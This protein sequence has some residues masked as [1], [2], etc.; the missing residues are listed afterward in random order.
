[1]Q[2]VHTARGQEGFSLVEL[3][4]SMV[5]LSIASIG[6][7]AAMISANRLAHSERELI[8][9]MNLARQK[10][11]EMQ[12]HPF[13]EIYARYNDTVADDPHDGSSPGPDVWPGNA[14]GTPALEHYGV[15][16]NSPVVPPPFGG[17]FP[18]QG[19]GP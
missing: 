15:H 4:V 2:G 5:V 9:A 10:L 8:G 13:E 16:G 6:F 12:A 3:I 7:A 14:A 1:M 18:G 19:R 11:E 17:P